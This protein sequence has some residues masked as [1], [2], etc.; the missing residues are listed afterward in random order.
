MAK[1]HPFTMPNSADREKYPQDPL[2]WRAY[3][4]DL[5]LNGYE[6]FGGSIRI[7]RRDI[8]NQV[9]DL[10]GLKEKEIQN[11]FGHMLEAFDYG[12]PPHGG[13][14]GGLDRI[15]AI[16]QNEPNIREVIPF[17]KTGD[18][19]D[20]MMAA[21]NVVG[22]KALKEANI[23]ISQAAKEQAKEKGEELEGFDTVMAE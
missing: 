11:R 9:F 19:R 12:A 18:N 15:V 13:I 20:L 7:H 2:K 3:A 8:Q 10:Q 6:I 21:P 14:A 17:P 23:E 5:V 4:Y 1:H 22:K 16:L